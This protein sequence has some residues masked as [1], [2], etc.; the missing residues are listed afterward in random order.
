MDLRDAW[1][2]AP[3]GRLCAW[4]QARALALREVSKMLHKGRSQLEWIAQRVEKVAIS[5]G[6]T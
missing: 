6:A 5:L 3:P 1:L 2:K 4:Q